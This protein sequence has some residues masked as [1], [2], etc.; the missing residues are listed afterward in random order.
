MKHVC[1][2]VLAIPGLLLWP[3]TAAADNFLTQSE[4]V[5]C[6][7][8]PDSSISVAG[9]DAVVCQGDFDQAPEIGAGAVTNGEGTLRWQVGNLGIYSPTTSMEYGHTYHRGNWTIYHD[10]TGTR[11][12]ND[13]TEHG[14]FVSIENVYAF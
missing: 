3:A 9:E 11:F 6:A 14:M 4:R 10:D 2:A 13:R 7:V 8:T 5:L 12:T 1:I